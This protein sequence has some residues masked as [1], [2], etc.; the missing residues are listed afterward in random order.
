VVRK[1]WDLESASNV[2][3]YRPGMWRVGIAAWEKFPLTGVGMDN[4]QLIT[5]RR[6]QEWRAA[7]AK[8]YDEKR[9][10]YFP[11]AH[12]LYV[13]TLTERGVFGVGVL[14]AVLL[15]WLAVALRRPPPQADDLDWT[16]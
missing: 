5:P 11:H 1:Q 7:A 13:N 12:S 4:F 10:I 9:Y 2:L 16:L 8:D 15:A 3:S 6:V 14:A